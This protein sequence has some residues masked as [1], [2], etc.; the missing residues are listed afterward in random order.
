MGCV[1]DF[2]QKKE[3]EEQPQ[4]LQKEE[5]KSRRGSKSM[6]LTV[7]GQEN[8]E[9]KMS[10]QSEICLS[11]Q[12]QQEIKANSILNI[13]SISHDSESRNSSSNK[14]VYEVKVGEVNDESNFDNNI[15]MSR[16]KGGVKGKE[17]VC[18]LSIIR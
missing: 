14:E 4:Q 16:I 9:Q 8:I 3:N 18:G 15:R 2:Q 1:S 7:N 11:L 5:P 17:R 12:S 10:Q 13:R 6:V